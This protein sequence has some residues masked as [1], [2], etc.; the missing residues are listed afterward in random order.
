[1]TL[2][3]AHRGASGHLPEHTLAAYQRAVADGADGVECDVRLTRDGH[4]V[5]VHDAMVD[6]TSDGRGRV[7]SL[8]L[9]ELNRFDFGRW[10]ASGTE[11]P[12][13]LTLDALL[14]FA[15]DAGRPLR[16]LI[17]TKHPSRFGGLVEERVAAA[18]SRYGLVTPSA[19]ASVAVTVMS[20]SPLAVRRMRAIA[21]A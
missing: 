4:L 13:V 5:C 20:F 19:A 9:A 16:L 10:H 2:V 18:L 14:A 11:S 1:M 6:R 17:E 21:V 3:F 8:T 12:G 7:S 15:V